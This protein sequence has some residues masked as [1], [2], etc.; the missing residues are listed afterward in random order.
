MKK[1]QR[2][3][4]LL[5]ALIIFAGCLLCIRV[6]LGLDF[7]D[8]THYL[9]LAKRFSQG[10]RPFREEW[11]PAQ[12]IG[13]LLLPFYYIY[14]RCTGG[15][16][17]IL[18]A[19]R[20]AFTLFHTA[21]VLLVFWRL[22][23]RK[24]TE[25]V[26][27]FLFSLMFLFYVRA[28]IHS[29]SYYNV[30]LV[31]F[32]LYLTVRG[33]ESA[34]VRFISGILFAVSVLCMPYLVLYFLILEFRQAVQCI[35]GRDSWRKEAVFLAGIACSAAVFLWFCLSSGDAGEILRNLPEI[36]KDPEHQG[37]MAG[38]VLSF[39]VFMVRVFYKYLFWPMVLEWAGIVYYIRKGRSRETLKKV[40]KAGAYAL[41][42]LQAVYVRT[43][44]EGGVMIAFF[45]LAVQI[46]AIESIRERELWYGYGLPG[47]FY[48]VIWMLGSNVGQRVFNMG[49][50]I[51]CL[52]AAAVIWKDC[53]M[54]RRMWSR[55]CKM[56]AAGWTLLIL[57]IISFLDIY[58]DSSVEYLTVRI[59][60]GAAK[61]IY[62]SAKRAEEY[63]QVLEGL[64][65]H[66]GEGRT[67]AAGGVN[68]WL[69]LEADAACGVQAVWRLDFADKRNDLYY[70]R[71]PKK[72]PDVIFL[73]NP[74]YKAYEGW[75]FS[76]HG[77]GTGGTEQ[78][79]EGCLQELIEEEDF[80]RV[81]EECG[82]FY[83]RG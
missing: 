8:E 11:F 40:L 70:E 49:C 68:P 64:S 62:T 74:S 72:V 55:V 36:L 19:A 48:G 33:E 20:V 23:K 27:A 83:V 18:L 39:A 35:R 38:S 53:R 66:A 47:L 21:A 30:G 4:C 46:S 32:L 3:I 31:T 26:P 43:F 75:R 29:F 24:Q 6:H 81:E 80:L 71:Y 65:A 51:S 58:R 37:T 76:S 59:E 28:N 69:Y 17:G 61:G 42:F 41:F 54:S 13:I 12:I 60:N 63:E 73:L 52:W 7:S 22:T 50:L 56:G 34:A 82:I 10:D 9:A 15:A 16:D 44:F 67:L 77:S 5:F 14:T 25:M 1:E 78:E 57:I 45:L 79:V 2:I